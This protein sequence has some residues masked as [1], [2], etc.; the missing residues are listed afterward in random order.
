MV[1]KQHIISF[2]V[3]AHN[4][5]FWLPQ[6]LTAIA[7]SART[8]GQTWEMIVVNDASTDR[9]EEVAREHGA[10]VVNVNHRQIAATRNAGARAAR[11]DR[12]IFV[13]ADT[14]ITPRSVTAAVR[15]M[16]QGAVGGGALTRF[17]R[18]APLYSHL[19]LWWLGFFTWVARLSGGAF[20]FCTRAAFDAVG[21]F[22]ENLYGAEDA[23]M[24]AALKREGRFVVLRQRLVTSAR[25]VQALSGLRILSVLLRIAFS[26]GDL[27]RRSSVEKV[28]YESNREKGLA[29][30]TSIAA[31]ISNAI[32]FV[33]L[34]VLVTMPLWIIP[35]PAPLMNS[36]LGSL[37]RSAGL[38]LVHVA[39]VLWPCALFLTRNLLRQ[40]RWQE[41]LQTALLILVSLGVAFSAT[42]QV[43]G[44]WARVISSFIR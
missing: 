43:C 5:E 40:K 29:P 10:I 27:T 31:R 28:W 44:F 20:M 39:L 36:P 17:E 35:W 6:T 30:S 15:C 25:R 33:I 23:A 21:G 24:S 11:G 13:D 14:T 22:N 42:V 7:E 1:Q 16:D 37:K 2:I 38:I 41:R 9:T 26:P 32:A 3:P 34:A 4:E 8:S 12:L 19:L 18:G